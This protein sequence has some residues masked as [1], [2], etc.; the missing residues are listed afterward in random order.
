[1]SFKVRGDNWTKQAVLLTAAVKSANTTF[2]EKTIPAY[3]LWRKIYSVTGFFAGVSD[4][5]GFYEYDT[6]IKEVYGYGFNFDEML[7]D[8][9]KLSQLQAR[10]MQFRSPKI[11]GGFEIDIGGNLDEL[12]KG[13]RL[14]GQRYAIDSQILGDLVYKNVGPNVNSPYYEEVIDFCVEYHI[15]SKPKEFYLSCENMAEN[16]TKYWNEVCSAAINLYL[17]CENCDTKS[18]QKLYS[19][20]RFVPTGLDVMQV[21]GSTKAEELVKKYYGYDYC[22]YQD[23]VARLKSMVGSYTQEEWTENLYNTWLWILQPLLKEK[24]EGYPNWM[25]SDVWKLKDLITSLASWAELRHDTI[26]YVKQ[27]YTWSTGVPGSAPVEP[28]EAK[29]YGYVEPNPEVF[30]RAKFATLFLRKWLEE[31]DIATQNVSQALTKTANLMERL[32]SIAKKELEG[33]ELDDSDYD[34][35]NNIDSRFNSILKQLASAVVVT[36]GGCPLGKRCKTETSLSGKD[37]AFKTTM[38]VDVHTEGN[39]KCVLETGV[40]KIDWIL[41]AHKSKDGRIGVCIGPVFSYYEFLWPMEDRLTDEK[42]RR[43]VLETVDRPVWYGLL[44]M[45]SSNSP[46]IIPK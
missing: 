22:D 5:L 32:E 20:C 10:L 16:K 45:G 25:R 14:I 17:R 7:S 12:T 39:T 4:D 27:S 40:G 46:Y 35:I 41:V 44:G 2:E 29:Y 34:F 42:W 36:G 33:R 9:D 24:P 18:L 21:L 30:A 26:L 19:V 3:E 23:E 13:L 11:L 6:A 31:E 28:L 15:C 38:V 43:E 37:D 8:A 1:M